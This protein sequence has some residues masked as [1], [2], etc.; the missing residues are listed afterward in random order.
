M[1]GNL[2]SLFFVSPKL[3]IDNVTLPRPSPGGVSSHKKILLVFLFSLN[4]KK[5]RTSEQSMPLE[6][7]NRSLLDR[8]LDCLRS[9]RKK[10]GV[11]RL[12]G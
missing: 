4:V 5:V 12:T 3:P 11:V 1:K 6:G 2:I 8:H 7:A 10:G 9:P